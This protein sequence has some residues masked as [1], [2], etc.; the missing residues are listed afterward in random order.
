MIGSQK[1]VLL[2]YQGQQFSTM[3][4]KWMKLEVVIKNVDAGSKKA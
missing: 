1:F 3:D 2:Y 4:K